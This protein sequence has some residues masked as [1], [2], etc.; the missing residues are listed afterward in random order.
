MKRWIFLA[1]VCA[2]ISGPAGAEPFL[3]TE[4]PIMEVFETEGII[5]VN[6]VSIVVTPLTSIT[7]PKGRLLHERELRPGR[8]VAVEAEPDE[9]SRIRA[10]RIVLIRRK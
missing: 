3:A 8:W 9:D 5:V 10:D 7:D 1:L 6:E 2:L 4:G